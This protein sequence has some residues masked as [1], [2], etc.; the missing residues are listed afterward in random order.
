MLKLTEHDLLSTHEV[1]EPLIA[2]GHVCHG[3]FD[4]TGA[5]VSPRTLHRVPAIQAWGDAH[6]TAFDTELVDIGLD[7]F[8]GH[9]PTVAQATL[10]IG[11]GAPEPIIS[12]LTRI[13][14]VEGFG[15]LLRHAPVPTMQPLFAESIDGT[16]LAHLDRGLI[17]CHARDE[18]GFESEAGHRD[19]WFAARDIAFERPV[20]EDQTELMLERMGINAAASGSKAATFVRKWPDDTSLELEVLIER[21]VRLMF[22]EIAAFHTFVWAQAVLGNDDLVAG[23]GEAARLVSY[24]RADETPHVGYLRVALSELRDRT[25]VGDTGRHHRGADL[26]AAIWEPAV[27]DQR[28]ARRSELE[29]LVAREVHHSLAGRSDEADLL[30]EY[31]SLADH[32]D[33]DA[34]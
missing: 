30:A 13:G 9:S 28:G 23:D 16:A 27:A 6:T 12:I 4:D 8:P 14:T 1:V 11:S 18:A 29:R 24:I 7:S 31:E 19:M 33:E 17:E 3:G 32:T 20:T 25:I 2:D 34:A 21:L 15:A 10:L 22:I 5:Y 26:L